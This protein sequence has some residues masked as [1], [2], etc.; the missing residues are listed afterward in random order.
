MV[1][2]RRCRSRLYLWNAVA[3]QAPQTL[4]G[5]LSY[6][7]PQ[8]HPPTPP[9]PS[10][11]SRAILVRLVG[12]C[13]APYPSDT[14]APRVP[15]TPQTPDRSDTSKPRAVPLRPS[16]AATPPTLGHPWAVPRPCNPSDTLGVPEIPCNRSERSR[17]ILGNVRGRGHLGQIMQGRA[18]GKRAAVAT[19]GAVAPRG[20]PGQS[21]CIYNTPPVDGSGRRRG[22][23]AD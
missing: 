2:L 16:G 21:I 22:A 3:T 10:E 19:S 5:G 15:P 8:L 14:S 23:G 18:S 1:S 9:A 11:P 4:S 12:Y 13:Q 20:P 17:A 6:C 7:P